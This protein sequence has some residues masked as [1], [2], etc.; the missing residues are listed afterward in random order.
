MVDIDIKGL[1][2]YREKNFEA[3]VKKSDSSIY[4][5]EIILGVTHNGDFWNAIGL[6]PDE[7]RA[8]IGLL[9]A[10]LKESTDG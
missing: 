3:E 7:A 1:R 4:S 8:V 5:D 10:Y 9:E 6:L 2:K